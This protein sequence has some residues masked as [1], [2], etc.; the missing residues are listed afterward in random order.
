MSR[1]AMT[2]LVQL[3]PQKAPFLFVD[4]ITEVGEE[5]IVGR[6][7]F[8]GEEHF[9]RGHFP[10][11]PITPGVILLECICQIALVAHGLYLLGAELSAEEL[12]NAQVLFTDG[13]VEF[14]S[15]VRPG[16]TVVVKSEKQF[17]RRRK[18]K[19][20]AKMFTVQGNL[21]ASAS[22]AGLEVSQH[23]QN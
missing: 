9:Y 10:G 6:Y 16:E 11:S 13:Q 20:N 1:P 19:A 7:T 3:L 15:V 8:T 23:G 22:V 2:E 21:I 17:W 14:E 12:I 4:E 5:R 18:L